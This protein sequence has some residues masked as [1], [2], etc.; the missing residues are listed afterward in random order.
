[1]G[2]AGADELD[3]GGD[4]VGRDVGVV[5]FDGVGETDSGVDGAASADERGAAFDE[6]LVDGAGGPDWLPAPL[7]ADVHPVTITAVEA[8][9]VTI[10]VKR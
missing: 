1:V 10:H 5:G 3:D 7:V 8:A 9:T 6:E 4:G 2:L